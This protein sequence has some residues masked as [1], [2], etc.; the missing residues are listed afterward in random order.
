MIM[1]GRFIFISM[2]PITPYEQEVIKELEAWKRDVQRRPGFLAA[3]SRRLQQRINRIIPEVAHRAITSVFKVTTKFLLQGSDF[4]TAKPLMNVSLQ[5][6]EE[7]AQTQIERY[8][9]A[10]TAEGAITGAGGILLGLA[11][12]PLWLTIKIKM[13]SHVAALYGHDTGDFRERLYILY[14][15]SLG[16]SSRRHKRKV[17]GI[18]AHWDEYVRT[19]PDEQ[20]AFDWRTFQQEYR[21]FLDIAKMLQLVPGIGAAIG[22]VVN[23]RLTDNLGDM[24][25]NAYR[26]RWFAQQGSVS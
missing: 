19:L 26:M 11:D 1:I 6:R 13:L 14:I 3:I 10:A 17:Y 21:D 12:L 8:K 5:E 7:N 16:F 23:N 4:L 24:A 2:A 20:D 15:L 25:M 22:A 9:Y 18:L